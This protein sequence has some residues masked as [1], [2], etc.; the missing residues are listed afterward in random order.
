MRVMSRT[1]FHTESIGASITTLA[2]QLRRM[3]P[4]HL[5]SLANPGYADLSHRSSDRPHL[6]VRGRQLCDDRGCRSTTPESTAGVEDLDEH[7]LSDRA[8]TAAAEASPNDQNKQVRMKG[9]PAPAPRRES[10]GAMNVPCEEIPIG[11]PPGVLDIRK[12]TIAQWTTSLLEVPCRWGFKRRHGKPSFRM[13]SL[14][15]VL[16]ESFDRQIEAGSAE[17]NSAI[18]LTELLGRGGDSQCPQVHCCTSIEAICNALETDVRTERRNRVTFDQGQT[19]SV[20][21]EE[22]H[23]VPW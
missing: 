12:A 1:T 16:I 8:A 5:R 19:P 7:D 13:R 21:V 2:S 10:P 9:R 22:P 17:D 4:S 11:F 14:G 15:S 6:D 23:G 3:R 18:L 20:R